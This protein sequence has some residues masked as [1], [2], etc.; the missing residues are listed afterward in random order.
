[1]TTADWVALVFLLAAL[2]ASVTVAALRALRAWRTFRSFSR[3]TGAALDDVM[4][5]AASAE[6]HAVSLT[7]GAEQLATATEHLQGSLAQLTLLRA[8]AGEARATLARLR[9]VVPGK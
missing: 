3:T 8:A 9:G 5:T 4:R 2:V 7:A 1:M 6:E